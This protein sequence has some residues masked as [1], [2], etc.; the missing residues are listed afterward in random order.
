MLRA[1]AMRVRWEVVPPVGMRDSGA[2]EAAPT[3]IGSVQR[4]LRLVDIVANSPRPVPVK[5]LAART[6]LTPGTTYNLVRTLVHE[7]YLVS[8]P[9]GLVLGENFPAFRSRS[10]AGGV[11]FALSLIHI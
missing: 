2:T 6:G 7:G 5:S 4:A 8:E 9:D 10:D 3:L 1:S 11:F